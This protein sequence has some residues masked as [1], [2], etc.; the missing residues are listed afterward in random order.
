MGIERRLGLYLTAGAP[1]FDAREAAGK[2]VTQSDRL[3]DTAANEA[4]N[5][6]RH[7]RFN[8]ACRDAIAAKSNS[9]VIL[10]DK[11]DGK[12]RARAL[13]LQRYA[14]ANDGHVADVIHKHGARNGN[15][16]LYEAKVYSSLCKSKRN[17][18]TGTSGGGDSP[19]TSAG[20]L[21]AFG[22]T[23]EWLL[24][25]IYGCK[26]RGSAAEGAFKHDS[27]EG[28]VQARR[29]CYHDG[30]H[31]KKNEV[32]AMI[33]NPFGGVT[34]TV[35]GVVRRLDKLPGTDRTVYGDHSTRSFYAHHAA[36]MSMACVIGDAEAIL[37]GLSQGETALTRD[38]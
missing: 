27:G 5:T 20:D 28:W 17:L 36:A 2:P 37:H 4:S 32:H 7:N 14:W 33:A 15:H 6:G 18:G 26:E 8:R 22:C 31:V 35:E 38:A 1:L 19:S 30:I 11:G 12:P 13:A 23:E 25:D 21:V 24:A 34:S 16:S 10:G 9:E 29:G 3:G